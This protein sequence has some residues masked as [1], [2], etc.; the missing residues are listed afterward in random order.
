MKNKQTGLSILEVMIVVAISSILL[1]ALLRFLVIGYPLSKITYLQQ[2]STETARLQLKRISKQLREA[3]PADTGAYALVEMSPQ[4]II[5][6]GDLDRDDVTERIRYELIGTDLVRG[7]IEPTGDPLAY[8]VTDEQTVTVARS[9]R[10]GESPIFTYYSGDYPADQT[11]LTPAD[12]TEVKYIQFHFL[13]DVDTSV[14]PPPIDVRSQVQL[15]NLK[16]NL[17]ETVE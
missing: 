7:I 13:I 10:N 16:T 14:D 9:I 5:F 1:I 8:V 6:Y 17:G 15:R 12:V 3:R 4:R 2:Q 11:A